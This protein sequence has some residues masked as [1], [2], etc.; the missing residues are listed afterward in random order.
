[1]LMD[2]AGLNP[3]ILCIFFPEDKS[4]YRT[5]LCHWEDNLKT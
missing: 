1:M 3:L 5:V 2:K 4:D